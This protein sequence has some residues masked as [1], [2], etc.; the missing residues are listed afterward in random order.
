MSKHTPGPWQ[1]DPSTGV[2]FDQVGLAVQ[3]GGRCCSEE[4]QANA[5]LIAAAPELL[6]AL[7]NARALL[8]G[9]MGQGFDVEMI[10]AAIAKA[11]GAS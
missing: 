9:E 6:E 7:K 10:D 2:V 5:Q 8:R 3:T 1:A 4:S 11:E